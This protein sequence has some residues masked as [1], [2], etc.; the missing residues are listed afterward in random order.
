V[1]STVEHHDGGKAVYDDGHLVE[2]GVTTLEGLRGW[3]ADDYR[4][5]VDRGGVADVMTEIA[6]RRFA[7]NEVDAGRDVAVFL[8]ELLHGVGR[9]RRGEHLS[10]GNVIRTEAVAALLRAVR[11][12]LPSDHAATLDRL[13]GLRRIEQAYPAL[14]TEIAAAIAQAPE[15]AAKALLDIAERHLGVGAGGLPPA[16]RDAVKRRLGWPVSP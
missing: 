6:S 3:V 9:S 13:D 16:A 15:P 2:W 14:A 10:A 1:L 12:T 11:A 7:A 8:F 4:V 5:L